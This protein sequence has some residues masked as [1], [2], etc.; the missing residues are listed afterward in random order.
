MSDQEIVAALK[1]GKK[2]VL[3]QLYGKPFQSTRKMIMRNSGNEQDAQ[4]IFQDAVIVFYK[5]CL[6]PGFQLTSSISTYLYSIS[7]N[8][9]LRQ[10]KG[11]QT[12]MD[13]Q[14]VDLKTD[15]LDLELAY[16]QND[17]IVQGIIEM[18][19]ILGKNCQEILLK[20]YFESKD[21]QEI[22]QD[23]EYASEHVVREKK[24][25]CLKSLREAVKKR[26]GESIK[27]YLSF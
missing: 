14:D 7:R 1:K 5:N 20:Y 25:R 11:Q 10:I 17:H 6:K 2:N 19:P 23:L 16:L 22:S 24:Y 8:L 13:T 4:D 26:F 12:F 9:W 18:M 21:H 15:E 3:S 27:E